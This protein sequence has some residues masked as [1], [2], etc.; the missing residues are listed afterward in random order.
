[1]AR[2]GALD[3]AAGSVAAEVTNPNAAVRPARISGQAS[4]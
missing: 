2:A 3:A 1:M 4:A